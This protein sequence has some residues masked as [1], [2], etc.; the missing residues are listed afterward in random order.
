MSRTILEWLRPL[1][2]VRVRLLWTVIEPLILPVYK[3]S[4]FRGAFGHALRQDHCRFPDNSC[5]SCD[6][7]SCVYRVLFETP[8]SPDSMVLSGAPYAP[9]P[10]TIVPPLTGR[11]SFSA[12]DQMTLVLALIGDAVRF[13]PE[14]LH[15]MMMAGR[16]GFGSKLQGRSGRLRMDRVDTLDSDWLPNSEPMYL[17]GD[18]DIR[19]L[20]AVLDHRDMELAYRRTI[21]DNSAV[22]IVTL[23]P[24]RLV[25]RHQ[26]VR[27]ISFAVL[28]RHLL[29]RL[30]LVM[31][32]HCGRYDDIDRVELSEMAET[33]AT[34]EQNLTW[35]DP[36]RWSERQQ[37]HIVMGG[38]IG[39]VTFGPIARFWFP[40]LLA[41]SWIHVGKGTVFGLGAYEIRYPADS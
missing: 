27:V 40:L 6:R 4:T 7:V 18:N 39:S 28:I 32:F 26:P 1:K 11:R 34:P 23:T 2:V 5:Q 29:R 36:R 13:I 17:T 25:E 16:E 19:G 24:L 38:F 21:D 37:R 33:I 30:R 20:P 8:V 3:G 14:C 35:T 10:F 12:G 31:A 15:A 9:H 22:K 41:G